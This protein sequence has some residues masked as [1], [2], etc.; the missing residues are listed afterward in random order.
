MTEII[1]RVEAGRIWH[2]AVWAGL[3]DSLGRDNDAN[4]DT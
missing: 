3:P 4:P 1:A 2:L